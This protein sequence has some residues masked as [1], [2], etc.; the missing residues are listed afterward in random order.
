MTNKSSL[1]L[2]AAATLALLAAGWLV[3]STLSHEAFAQRSRAAA[4]AAPRTINVRTEPNAVVWLDDVRRGTTDEGGRLI[5]KD[6]RPGRH[7]LRVRA[8]GFQE[9]RLPLLPTQRGDV[10]VRLTHTTDEAELL[11][12]QAEAA[13]EKAASEEARRE[14]AALYRRALELRPRFPAAHVGLARV[15]LALDDYDAALAEIRAARRDRPVYP[16]ASA[17]EGRIHRAA[18]FNDEAAASYRRAIREARGFQPEAYTGLGIVLSDE[19]EHE[20]AVAAFRQ[21]IAQLSDTEPILYQLLG[22]TY[23]RLE[24]YKE[25]VAAYEKYLELAPEGKL[26]PAIRSIIDQLREQAAGQTTP[27]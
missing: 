23:E 2:A 20:E 26:A 15:L 17:V 8:G 4:P 3:T 24:K 6:V 19:G 9:R 13:S 14:A 7:T 12:Q 18:A 21:A 16:E 10:N 27:D 22:A 1:P 5:I 11:F 25:A